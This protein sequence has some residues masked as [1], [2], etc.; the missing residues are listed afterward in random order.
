LEKFESE[1]KGP[2][3]FYETTNLAGEGIWRKGGGKK[4]STPFA[5]FEL[6]HRC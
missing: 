2:K 5:F 6:L 1:T 3:T 4:E